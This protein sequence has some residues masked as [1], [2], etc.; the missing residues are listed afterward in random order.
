MLSVYIN[1]YM[2]DNNY[3]Y[4]LL[5]IFF[6]L[7]RHAWPYRNPHR[8]STLRANTSSYLVPYL[9][10]I[11]YINLRRSR[12]C[13]YVWGCGSATRASLT[14]FGD[15]LRCPHKRFVIITKVYIARH[16]IQVELIRFR[17]N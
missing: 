5:G 1:E 9:Q 13:L 2:C 12:D 16:N 8:G 10:Y 17:T 15:M 14:N 7:S 4:V 3:C 11:Y 6:L